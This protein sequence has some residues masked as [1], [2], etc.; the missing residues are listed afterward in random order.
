MRTSTIWVETIW[1]SHACEKERRFLLLD[2][3]KYHMQ[4]L[5]DY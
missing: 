1:K 5:F 2:E 4:D 3:C